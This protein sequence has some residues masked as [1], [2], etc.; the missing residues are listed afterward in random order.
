[1]RCLCALSLGLSLGLPVAG[2][3]AEELQWRPVVARPGVGQQSSDFQTP[4]TPT[5]AVGRA[6]PLKAVGTDQPMAC[7]VG[8]GRPVR[9][10]ANS[11]TSLDA[12]LRTTVSG[13]GQP[14][15]SGAVVFRAKREDA[16]QPVPM[17]P[18]ERIGPVPTPVGNKGSSGVTSHFGDDCCTPDCC[19]P[20]C[21][22]A[23]CGPCDFACCGSACGRPSRFWIT[24]EYL[25]WGI[26][27]SLYP[28]LVTA[29]PV[30]V[31]GAGL[32]TTPGTATVL[33]GT[34]PVNNEEMS[35]ARFGIG[36]W[37]DPCRTCGLETSFFWLGRRSNS[38]FAA[39]PGLPVLARPFLDVTTGVPFENAQL[40]ASP[41]VLSGSVRVATTTS[42]WG[43]DIDLRKHLLDGSVC[44][45][46]YCLDVLGGFRFLE[47]QESVT[48]TEN[49]AILPG[50]NVPRLLTATGPATIGVLDRFQTTNQFYGGQ[51]GFEGELIRGRWFLGL[52]TKLG[53]GNMHESVNVVGATAITVPSISVATFAPGGL[54]TQQSNIGRRNRDQFAFVPEI[55][56]KVG[57]NVSDHLRVF[58][59]YNFLYLSTVVRPGDQID[60]A[61][62]TAQLPTIIG[63]GTAA[64]RP[65]LT[66]RGNDFWAQGLTVGAE[67]RY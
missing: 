66:L 52:N 11:P 25:L 34:T 23:R 57:Y 27:D 2:A 4:S 58:V 22:T 43:G 41:G 3:L 15:C 47:L 28:P 36:F 37:L 44:G 59:G 14:D 40:V 6:V 12:N 42:L 49:L 55:G 21:C 60:R 20:D 26:K 18:A 50:A 29:S 63:A 19:A 39:S 46:C 38:F 35:G 61:V 31:P 24:G 62:N 45:W 7:D 9:C 64:S 17:G 8:I 16:I 67:L 13:G 32:I 1:M 5:I 30:A 10:G 56:L 33:G 51:V 54:L 65:A 48:I 53:L